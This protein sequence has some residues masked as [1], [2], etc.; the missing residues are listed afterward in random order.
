MAA[1]GQVRGPSFKKHKARTAHLNAD[2]LSTIILLDCDDLPV[3][4]G[5]KIF[6]AGNVQQEAPREDKEWIL[7][8]IALF[9]FVI[10]S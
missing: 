4:G 1:P 7:Q 2:S 5:P 6:G 3:G 9:A 10:C 8:N